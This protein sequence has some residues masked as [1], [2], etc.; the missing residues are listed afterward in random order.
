MSPSQSVIR[1][2]RGII[3]Y[4]NWAIAVL[5][6][7]ALIAVY[8]VA[9]RPLPQTSGELAAPI[10]HQ[11]TVARDS[12][13][14]PHITA[15]TLDDALFL[16]GYVTAQ[17]RLWQMD[18]LR[19]L[20]AGDLSEVI[21]PATLE[22]DRESRRLRMRRTA[23]AHARTLPLADRAVLV[24]YARGVNYFIRTHMDRLPLEFT[25]L[26][27]DPRPWTV[28]DSLLAGLQMYRNL[29]NIYR[30]EFKKQTMLEGG[31]RAK[32]NFLFPRRSGREFQPG[33][34]AWAISGAHTASGRPLL[35]NDPHL[36]YAVPATWYMVHLQAPGFNVTGVSLPGVPCVIIGHN[37][38]IAWGVTNLGFD[39]QDLYQEQ[40]DPNS[41][42]Y[43]FN[44][45]PEQAHLETEVIPV[46]GARPVDFKQWVTRHGPVIASD[47]N[48]Y[49]ALRWAASEPGSFQFPFADINRAGNWQEFT[50]ALARF[51]GPG[52][53]FVYADIDGNIGYHATGMLPLRSGYDGS[54]PAD[55]SSGQNE[56]TGFIRFEDLPSSYNPPSGLIVTANQNPFPPDYKYQVDGEFAPQYRSRQIRDL[57]MARNGLKPENMLTVQKDVYSGFSDYLAKR[58]VTAF[59]RK[60]AS[61]S[62][63]KDAIAVLRHW[64]GQMEKE[65]AAPM[66]AALTYL[67]YRKHVAAVASPGKGE[68]YE[69]QMAP[70]VLQQILEND[71]RGWFTDNNAVLLQCLSEALEA[72]RHMQGSKVA[73]WDYGLY[74]E[75]T[76]AQPVGNQLPGVGSYF[77]IGPIPMSGS[78]TTVK[79]TTRK[80]GPSMR[81]VADLSDWDKSLNNLTVGE[82]GQILSSHYKDQWKAYYTARSFPMQFR[83]IDA[84]HTLTIKP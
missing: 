76:I 37:E 59:D 22:A 17:D 33:S 65:T 84:K 19:R 78:S 66:I 15:A 83:K 64:N 73:N 28:V 82:S 2:N 16:Q 77:N 41:G 61:N 9:Y 43:L 55:G 79:Q 70:A 6:V 11:A 60:H 25:I 36:D 75:L 49:F 23:E 62:A 13:G 74:N 14:V 47:N 3:R 12:L 1:H 42:R 8:W 10:S 21:G 39:V 53:N 67:Q 24:A 58:L 38:R 72:G 26:G 45:Q 34:N 7:A 27:Y 80:L 30:D 50:A 68:V 31:D 52:Q 29:T 63:Q 69:N 51:P 81:F 44:G 35:A 32:V 71:G 46:K 57:L 18:A 5:V 48:K 56:W 4:I 40:L 20:A 54:L